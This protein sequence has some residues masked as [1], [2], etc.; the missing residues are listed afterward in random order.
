VTQYPLELELKFQADDERPLDELTR[1]AELG[2]ARLGPASTVDETDRYLDTVDL[3]LEARRWACRLRTR[4]G[5]TVVSLKGPAEHSIGELLHQRPELEGPAA[6]DLESSH[7]PPSRAR[8]LL[9]TMCGGRPLLERFTLAQ[10]RTERP[11]EMA[12]RRCGLLSLD[13]STVER[14]GRQVGLV[15]TVELELDASAVAAGLDHEPLARALTRVPGLQPD[16]ATKLEHAL[17]L[18]AVEA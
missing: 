2:P 11:V 4:N 16:P 17:Q 1:A 15:R 3:R 5:R 13:R 6:D 18:L 10:R 7:W 12:G 9:R 14:A 8:D